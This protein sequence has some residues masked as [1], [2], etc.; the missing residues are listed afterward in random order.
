MDDVETPVAM[1]NHPPAFASFG[2]PCHQ[3]RIRKR[4]AGLHEQIIDESDGNA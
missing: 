3:L 1:N 4:F 2:P